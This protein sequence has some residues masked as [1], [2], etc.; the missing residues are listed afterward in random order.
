[1]G[2]Y[3]L[4][5]Y[6]LHRSIACVIEYLEKVDPQAA[7]LA[8]RRYGCF[9]VF[10][11]DPQTYGYAASTRM[12]PSC[13]DEVVSQL[14]DLQRRAAEYAQRDGRIAADEYSLPSRTRAS[15]EMPK[16]YYRAMFRGGAESWNLRDRHMMSTLEALLDYAERSGR[17]RRAV[18]WAHNSHLGDARA[19]G[20][21]A[22]GS[23][24][25]G[26]WSASSTGAPAAWSE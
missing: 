1:M 21:A 20:F 19:T 23:S 8:R 25:S 24:I 17:P 22:S 10:G 26:S 14:M 18:V 5:L 3:G 4:E 6:S 2:F 12:A 11:E 15:S 13:E 7:G 16:G 9:D